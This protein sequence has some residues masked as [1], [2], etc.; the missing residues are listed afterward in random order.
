MALITQSYVTWQI[1]L[2]PFQITSDWKSSYR[3]GSLRKPPSSGA[4][5]LSTPGLLVGPNL[6]VWQSFNW[7][8]NLILSG[9]HSFKVKV[10]RQRW[11]WDFSQMPHWEPHLSFL[12]VQHAT[13]WL[14]Q[15]LITRSSR[16]LGIVSELWEQKLLLSLNLLQMES[17]LLN[18]SRLSKSKKWKPWILQEI[19]VFGGK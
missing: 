8:F 19:D 17:W 16:S 18:S 4:L 3:N 5:T 6:S 11:P 10:H 15:E 14:G 12:T 2:R 9:W 7:K 1:L 13:G